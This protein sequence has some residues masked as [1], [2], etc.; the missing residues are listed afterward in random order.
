MR[1]PLKRVVH[2]KRRV[3]IPVA[4]GLAPERRGVRGHRPA[5]QRP[6]ARRRSAGRRPPSSNCR[7]AQREDNEA[8]GMAQGR[9]RTDAAL[10]AFY[11]DVLPSQLRAGAQCDVPCGCRSSPSSTI[12]NLRRGGTAIPNPRKTPRSRACRCR[13]R[14]SGDYD[15]I[16]RFIYQVES[17]SDFI[18]ID[19]I[20]LA[21]STEPGA[22]LTFDLSLS[23]YYHV[24]PDGA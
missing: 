4:A 6:R 16:R 21:Q 14:C 11:K 24:G 13:C 9:D 8:R 1:L 22:P 19:S 12:S 2:E 3:I 10:K 20:A 7:A 18:V 23:T 17:G 5:A 15:D